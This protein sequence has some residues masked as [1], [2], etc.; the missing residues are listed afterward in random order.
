[1]TRLV[2]G[3]RHRTRQGRRRAGGQGLIEFALVLPIIV[4]LGV[5]FIELGRAVYSYTTITNAARQASRVAA[6]NQL[7]TTTECDESRPIEDPADAHWTVVGCALTAGATL[8][9]TVANVTV[10]Y[11]APPSTTVSCSPTI[12]V[13]CIA[14]VTVT[15]AY[16]A[17]TP[18]VSGLIHNIAMTSTSQMPVE[19]VFP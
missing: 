17:A 1:L 12:H 5:A 6:V 18:L 10:S 15:Y 19:R 11:S 8:G 4:L 13:G 16:S 2:R 9:I 3:P 14:S 7:A